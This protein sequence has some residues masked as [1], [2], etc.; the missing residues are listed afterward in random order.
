MKNFMWIIGMG[1]SVFDT[2]LSTL[3]KLMIK[4]SHNIDNEKTKKKYF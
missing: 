3:G 4:L 2:F 1:I